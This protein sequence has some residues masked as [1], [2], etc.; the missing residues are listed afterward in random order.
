MTTPICH[1]TLA[2]PE[3]APCIGSKCSM[4]EDYKRL[5]TDTGYVVQHSQGRGVCHENPDAV[6]WPD[7]ARAVGGAT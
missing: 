4:W 1:R 3:P 2:S 7:P 5:S 6:P